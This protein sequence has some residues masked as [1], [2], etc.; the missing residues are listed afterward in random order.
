MVVEGDDDNEQQV[1]N[2][3]FMIASNTC[4][5]VFQSAWRFKY[6]EKHGQNK[7]IAPITL[8]V[9]RGHV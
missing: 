3:E 5:G 1:R 6:L 9:F 4:C 7:S 8:S 2:L